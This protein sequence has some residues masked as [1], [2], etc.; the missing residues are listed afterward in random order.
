MGA[1]VVD[2]GLLRAWRD[3]ARGRDENT[4]CVYQTDGDVGVGV[5]LLG[6]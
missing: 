1:T 2:R 3:T 5:V 4:V 6:P